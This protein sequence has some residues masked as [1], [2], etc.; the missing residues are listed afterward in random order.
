MSKYTEVFT[1]DVIRSK[2]LDAEYW[3]E[4]YIRNE[5]VLSSFRCEPLGRLV[6]TLKKGVF[7]ILAS[8]YTQEGIPFYR[9][10]NV[11]EIF[12][13]EKNM[14]Y[15]SEEKN[16]SE[17]KTSLEAGDI[18]LSKTGKNAAS[19][20]FSERCNV[21][22]DVVA[23]KVRRDKINPYYLA[24]YL[25]TRIGS[26][27]L[28]RRFQGQVQMH[29]SLPETRKCIIPL[30]SESIQDAVE[31]KV[32]DA[33]NLNK[34]S[35]DLYAKALNLLEKELGLDQIEDDY[36]VFS[37]SSFMDVI[38]SHRL[39]AQHYQNKYVSLIE[40][41]ALFPYKKVKEIRVLNRRGLQP[42]YI[43][44]GGLSVINSQH[45]T[46]DHL[47]Y[48]AFEET[49][50]Y[51]YNKSKVAH[52]RKGDVLIYTTGAYIGQ[53]NLYDSNLPAMASNHV[54]ILRVNGVDSGY[55]TIVLQSIIGKY[56][57][58]KHARGSAQAELYPTDIDKFI[59]PIIGDSEQL[60]IGDLLRQSLIAKK[61]SEQLL[62]QAKKMVEELIEGAI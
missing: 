45:I 1:N 47:D 36:C 59:I 23:I 25:N 9:S 43:K 49:S 5:V 12:P 55:L 41:L 31:V 50:L 11:G 48:G 46:K 53:A 10:A 58:Q 26:D 42:K 14:V 54:N 37:E 38:T 3:Q 32:K 30:A 28:V 61:E 52:V 24:V 44:N 22:Q 17:I 62:D 51:E 21:S 6:S 29:L 13:N 35:N 57:T 4:K 18:M 60:E 15:I 16:K 20:V 27:E 8:E 19:V 56:Q 39:D 7:Y 2:R 40:R 34:Y 33:F